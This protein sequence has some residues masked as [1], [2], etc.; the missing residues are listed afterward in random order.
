MA[1]FTYTNSDGER[2]TSTHATRDEA[3]AARLAFLAQT[4]TDE[5]A[6]TKQG[7]VWYAEDTGE[8]YAVR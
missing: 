3:R 4:D 7:D 6:L 1:R 2:E 8:R 5:T